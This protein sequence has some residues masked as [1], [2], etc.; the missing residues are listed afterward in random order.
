[1]RLTVHGTWRGR[2]VTVVWEDGR[3]TTDPIEL[4]H[5]FALH[6]RL[7]TEGIGAPTSTGQGEGRTIEDPLGML[8]LASTL[9]DHIDGIGDELGH[10]SLED[11]SHRL[12]RALESGA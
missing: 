1:M 2:A 7:R 9:L 3:L 10:L 8:D 4:R 6:G 5:L 11:R 12:S